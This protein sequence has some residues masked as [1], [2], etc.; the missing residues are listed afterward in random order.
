MLY[1][2]ILITL[3]LLYIPFFLR[4]PAASLDG[5][6]SVGLNQAIIQHLQFGKDIVFTYGPYAAI[7][8]SMYTPIVYP[9][10]VSASIYFCFCFFLTFI[11]I[12][13]EQ[14][15]LGSIFL[16]IALML[17]GHSDILFSTYPLMTAFCVISLLTTEKNKI[18]PFLLS[19][20]IALLFSGFGLLILIKGTFI[21]LCAPIVLFSAGLLFFH[22][23]PL[24]ASIALLAPCFS[25]IIFWKLSAQ[26]GSII[27]YLSSL[28]PIISGYSNA[29]S[30]RGE[31]QE[32]ILFLLSA[33]L[34][35]ITLWLEKVV[36]LTLTLKYFMLFCF[37][38][39]LF[40][41]FKEA[42]VR[43][44][45]HAL[46][47]A[48]GLLAAVSC[49]LFLI[50]I[51][52]TLLSIIQSIDKRRSNDAHTQPI[53]EYVHAY[54]IIL[55]LGLSLFSAFRI[56][57][58]YQGMQDRYVE[59]W[60]SLPDRFTNPALFYANYQNS[61]E[62]LKAKA[63]FPI[64][65]GTVD[66]YSDDQAY[67]LTSGNVWSPRPVFQ[68][69]AAYTPE[70]AELNKAHLL[71]AAAPAHIV[72]KMLP[73]DNRLP[74]LED[75]TSWPVLLSQYTLNTKH[76]DFLFL[77]RKENCHF[78][79]AMTPIMQQNISLRRWVSLP[80][81]NHLL[82]TQIEI[83]PSLMGKIL[84]LLYKTPPLTITIKLANGSER[85]YRFIAG[86]AESGFIL[87]P[88][89]ENTDD[90]AKLYG[91]S[92]DLQSNRIQ[93]MNISVRNRTGIFFKKTYLIKISEFN[94][95]QSSI[96]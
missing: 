9:L 30:F 38:L 74:A 63:D 48:Y 44:D 5:S 13:N 57:Y 54:L 95:K 58:H 21:V 2:F 15:F 53:K 39:F 31:Y 55:S 77:D 56:L 60:R 49:S 7:K 42:F 79:D 18:H 25:S 76:N 89:V 26:S 92:S 24:W 73:I 16:L 4:F 35:I 17:D 12:L 70:L 47:A 10:I 46:T 28:I 86:M 78:V 36:S 93:K 83:H 67:L 61:L 69:Y 88:F 20:S 8:T 6:W 40:L 84:G 14:T 87:S 11:I 81:T 82:Y 71:G 43:H 23:K 91:T 45:A 94:P 59:N 51:P 27:T 90:F 75:G 68:S 62:T 34:L 3:M 29:M 52:K 19:L 32:V 41:S 96:C 85:T 65:K 72:F 50:S 22:K 80:I 64:W 37:S 1:F 33:G 66:L